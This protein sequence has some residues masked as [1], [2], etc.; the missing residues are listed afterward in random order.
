MKNIL[1]IVYCLPPI[2]V[3]ATVRYVKWF[4]GLVGLGHRIET[5]SIDPDS[6]AGPAKGLFDDAL[7]KLVP[8][9]VINHRVWSW[10]KNIIL[11]NVKKSRLGY[12]LF[13]RLFE[14]RKKE[15]Y[16]PAIRC[17]NN[18]NMDS[19]DVIL[20]CSQPHSCHL[21]GLFLKERTG[22]PWVAYFSDPWIDSPY[23]GYH[24]RRI[25]DYNAGMEKKVIENADAIL[26]TTEETLNL[27]AKNYPAGF[28]DKMRIVPHCFVPEWYE[29]AKADGF[30]RNGDK[31]RVVHTGHFYGPRTPMP[32]FETMLRLKREIK[33]I[34]EK[35]EF[36]FFGN[37]EQKYQDFI[38]KNGLDDLFRIQ[39]TISYIQSLGLMKSADYLLLIDAPLTHTRESV[40]LP[41]KLIDYIGSYKCV[42]GITPAR[43]ASANVLRDTGNLVCDIHDR[44][45]IYEVFKNIFEGSVTIRPERTRIN[46]YNC[47]QITRE[48]SDIITHIRDNER[49]SG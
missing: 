8:E 42:I 1:A 47:K 16:Y 4:T 7:V 36:L 27:V 11:R 41:S 33:D 46:R 44:D 38:T 35:I 14:P 3:P 49:C 20:S 12:S 5:L 32:L 6:F 9:A 19:F 21:V 15:W 10:E 43:G 24:S 28:R 18:L 31:I 34:S 30:E 40:F 29:L 2:L 48:L 13:Y 22:K 37:M 39:G 26:F 17:L 45:S 25:K 23:A